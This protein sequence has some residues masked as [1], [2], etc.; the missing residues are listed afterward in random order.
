MLYLLDTDT[1]I[2]V[3][4]GHQAS[5]RAKARRKK[6]ANIV[7]RC[8][9]AQT[10]GDRVGVSAVT[11]SELEF[12]AQNSGQYAREIS[13]VRKI[14]APFELLD[15]DAA[16]CPPHYGRVRNDLESQGRPIGSMELFIAAHALALDATLVTN[17]AGH[18]ARVAGLKTVNWS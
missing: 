7:R 17:N 18:F 4:R 14:L 1:L 2:F 13:A 10:D 3:I 16:T 8:Q 12:G 15:Y 5:A 9:E 6:A 11:V